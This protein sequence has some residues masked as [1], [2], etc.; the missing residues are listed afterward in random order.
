M[1]APSDAE[2][3]ERAYFAITPFSYLGGGGLPLGDAALDLV[4][5]QVQLEAAVGDVELDRV[6]VAHRRDRAAVRRLGRDVPGHQA[7][8]RAGEAA[9]GE[10][11]DRVAQALAD[12]RR[13][14]GEHLAH[15]GAAARPLVADHD[16][17]VRPRSAPAVTA[18]IAS[19]SHSNTRAG[20]A[21]ARALVAG[22]LHD[23]ALR[24]EVAAQ[25]H[26][27]AASP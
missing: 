18:A 11:R 17:V 8:R 2:D 5:G 22:D 16:H 6:A 25:D 10:Q 9:V 15:A 27:P 19:S 21:V 4:L 1:I 12:E 7:V 3:T 13:R 20:P 24:G 26:E 14:D 23:A